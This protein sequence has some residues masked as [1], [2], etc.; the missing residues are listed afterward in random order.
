MCSSRKFLPT[1]TF[2]LVLCCVFIGT[3]YC[4]TQAITDGG[5]TEWSA[6]ANCTKTCGE[7]VQVRYRSCSNPSPGRYGKDCY[8]FGPNEDTKPCFLT[9]C[10]VDGKY[11]DWGPFSVCDKPCNGGKQVR[12]R[13]CNNPPPVFGGRPCE[14]PDKEEK[15]CN[16]NPCVP[17]NGGFTEWGSYSACSV[18]CGKGKMTRTRSCTNPAPLYGG[19]GCDGPDSETAECDMEPCRPQQHQGKAASQAPKPAGKAP[20]NAEQSAKPA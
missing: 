19:K 7:G 6:W 2:S 14:G 18:T 11:S 8:R 12:T 13:Q 4:F 9:I 16:T 15:D 10:P 17:V 3:Y 20:E 5:Y 1:F